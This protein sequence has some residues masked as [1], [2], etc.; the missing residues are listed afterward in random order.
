MMKKRLKALLFVL[1]LLLAPL[2]GAEA[3]EKEPHLILN[4]VARYPK[5]IYP[6]D[7]MGKTE[8]ISYLLTVTNTGDAACALRYLRFLVGDDWDAEAFRDTVLEAGQS[9]TFLHDQRFSPEDV[10]PGTEREGIL[11]EAEIEFTV[12]GGETGEY[13]SNIA[14]LSHAISAEPAVGL[15]TLGAEMVQVQLKVNGASV[16]PAG[17]QAGEK[18]NY[19]VQVTNLSS[20]PLPAL[21]LEELRGGDAEARQI[22]VINGL[23]S[24]GQQT[25]TYTH[26]VNE[27]D[28]SQGY[29]YSAVSA[30]WTDPA[31]REIFAS[32]SAPRVVMTLRGAAAPQPVGEGIQLTANAVSI[33]ANGAYYVPGETVLISLRAVNASSSALN[34]VKLL[35]LSDTGAGPLAEIPSLLPGEEAAAEL[36]C[37]VTELDALLGGVRRAAAVQASDVYGNRELSLSDLLSLP[38][39]QAETAAAV[40]NVHQSLTLVQREISSPAQ[41]GAY[42]AGETVSYEIIVF[43]V[44]GEGAWDVSVRDILAD[45]PVDHADRLEPGDFARFTFDHTVTEAEEQAGRVTAWAFAT[46]ERDGSFLGMSRAAAPSI[47]PAGNGE[48]VSADGFDLPLSGDGCSLT[49][50]AKGSN[51]AEY[52]QHSCARHAEISKT[53]N[54]LTAAAETEEALL[55][56]WEQAAALW[57]EELEALYDDYFAAASGAARMAV[58]QERIASLESLKT[59][60]ALMD[61]IYAETPAQAARCAAEEAMRRCLQLCADG[62]SAPN[63]RPDSVFQAGL[64]KIVSTSAA[65]TCG[66]MTLFTQDETVHYRDTLCAAHSMVEE[67]AEV[68]LKSAENSQSARDLWFSALRTSLNERYEKGGE[69]TRAAVSLYLLRMDQ[70]LSAHAETLALLYPDDPQTAREATAQSVMR[71]VLALCREALD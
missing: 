55:S 9:V 22:T 58:T 18:I 59:L 3:D 69:E 38:V 4:A 54:D 50:L 40:P 41:G 21:Q 44:A 31:S 56:A 14:R 42:R 2:C 47:S 35:D 6:L 24:G 16:H 34:Q 43:H 65:D 10:L 17:Y 48:S 1:I 46:V 7:M 62:H 27:S 61:Q 12:I 5:E 70:Y 45:G 13:V 25:V 67:A 30:A 23:A 52:S 39:G 36:A 68:L 32:R 60:R 20:Q 28:L 11:G 26:T 49:L 29:L 57:T 64:G 63:E 15:P 19:Q 8:S 71:A 33:P 51:A 37:T 53:V 66:R